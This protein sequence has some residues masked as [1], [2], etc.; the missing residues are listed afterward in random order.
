MKILVVNDDS[1]HAPGIALLAKAAMEL[2]EVAVVAPA[3]QCSAMSQK[4]TIRGDMRVDQV[5]DFP[6]PVKAAYMVDGTPADCVKI[7]MQHLLEEKPDYV[8]SGINDGYNAGYDIAYSGT[9]GAAFE[10]V[11]NG[12][13]AM[14]FS[15]TMNAPLHIA[16]KYLVSIMRELMEAGQG[17]GEVWNVNF[18]AVAPEKLKG[19]LRDRTVAPLQFYSEDY[20][21]TTLPDGAVVALYGDLGAGKTAFVRGMARGMGI[22]ARVSS[23][24]F[25]IVNEYLGARELYHFDMYRLASSDELFDIGWEDYLR[26]GGVCAVEWSE[27]VADAF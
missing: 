14:A 27:N 8:F 18:P 13:P 2:G 9:L 19:I 20:R 12:V 21:K 10:A 26:R 25:T 7:A 17:R 3:H 6:V 11:M 22:S 15:S 23:P 24:T 4:I 16:D 5:T 1:I